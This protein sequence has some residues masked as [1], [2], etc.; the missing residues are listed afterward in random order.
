MAYKN[1]DDA[2]KWYLKNRERLLPI[3]RA[4]N[5]KW[6]ESEHGVEFDKERNASPERKTYRKKYKQTEAGK[7]SNLKY[8]RKPEVKLKY[9]NYRLGVRYGITVEKYNELY[10]L[11]QGKCLI[12]GEHKERLDIDHSHETGAVRGL[13]CGKCNKGIGLFGDNPELL[14]KAIKYLK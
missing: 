13:L 14:S 12:C 10:R 3:R 9:K 5:K 2:K 7:K 4:Y 1:P 6:R 8:R 11:Q